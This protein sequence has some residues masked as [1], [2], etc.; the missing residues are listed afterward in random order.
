MTATTATPNAF[1]A[2]VGNLSIHRS[3]DATAYVLTVTA[4]G[5][6]VGTYSTAKQAND[7]GIARVA[8]AYK[9]RA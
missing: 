8:A 6:L 4:T 5:E 2:R 1:L 7:A 3:A 9:A